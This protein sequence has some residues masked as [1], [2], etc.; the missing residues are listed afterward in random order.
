ML[1]RGCSLINLCLAATLLAWVWAGRL[2]ALL[3][4]ATTVWNTFKLVFSLLLL[5]TLWRSGLGGSTLIILA[6]AS[7]NTNSSY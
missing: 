5:L 1:L 7:G 2:P 6:A 3:R 4:T